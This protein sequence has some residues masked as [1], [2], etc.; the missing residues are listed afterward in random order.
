MR[1]LVLVFLLLVL[2]FV[3]LREP[4]EKYPA[5]AHRIVS[6]A[7]DL[8]TRTFG[9]NKGAHRVALPTT[10]PATN[11][12]PAVSE[13]RPTTVVPKSPVA[14][15]RTPSQGESGWVLS[16]PPV[17][18]ATRMGSPKPI[19]PSDQIAPDRESPDA[20]PEYLPPRPER[21]R[22][23]DSAGRAAPRALYREAARLLEGVGR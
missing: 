16:S 6:D 11:R 3:A 20:L 22:E 14:V 8:A 21:P 12:Q 7:S 23:S 2:I 9:H 15:S 13:P 19:I 1:T 4:G 5:A 17:D 10:E 18:A